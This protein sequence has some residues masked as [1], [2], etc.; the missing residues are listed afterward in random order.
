MKTPR[1]VALPFI[2]WCRMYYYFLPTKG[3]INVWTTALTIVKGREQDSVLSGSLLSSLVLLLMRE[4]L[5]RSHVPIA[6]FDT[7]IFPTVHAIGERFWTW[8]P[9]LLTYELDLITWPRYL[10]SWPPCQDSGLYVC[11]LGQD[12]ET[13]R[14][15]DNAKT[16]TP[17][18]DAG[19]KNLRGNFVIL[20]SSQ[21]LCIISD[22]AL[23]HHISDSISPNNL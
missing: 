14:Q 9:W 4:E 18:S 17:S 22:P 7:I 20:C 16:I 15:T 6:S 11:L 2:L 3:K 19:C 13:H 1:V 12:S 5:Q 21:I 8:W 23:P 10:H